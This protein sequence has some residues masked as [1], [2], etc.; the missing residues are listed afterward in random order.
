MRL[1]KAIGQTLWGQ[2]IIAYLCRRCY[3]SA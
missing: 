1:S 3:T 2:W